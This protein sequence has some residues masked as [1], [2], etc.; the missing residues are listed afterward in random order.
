M[1]IVA[2]EASVHSFFTTYADASRSGVTFESFV[3]FVKTKSVSGSGKK[4]V[5][6]AFITLTKS[7]PVVT[8]REVGVTF[9]EN[10]DLIMNALRD[11]PSGDGFDYRAYIDNLFA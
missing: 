8:E 6:N 4:D 10:P 9:S 1:G 3:D 5:L 11:F 7:A 2:D